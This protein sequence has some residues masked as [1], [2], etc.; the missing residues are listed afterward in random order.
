MPGVHIF[1]LKNRGKSA[2]DIVVLVVLFD[3]LPVCQSGLSFLDKRTH[4]P[5]AREKMLSV[6]F[7]ESPATG[8]DTPGMGLSPSRLTEAMPD[9]LLT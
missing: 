5:E 4:K 9:F 1:K 3:L 2:G 6:A 7:S 8:I